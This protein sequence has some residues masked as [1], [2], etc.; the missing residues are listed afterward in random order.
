[1]Y[2]LIFLVQ[3]NFQAAVTNSAPD[4]MENA[5]IA[6]KQD[7]DFI[8]AAL[9]AKK[10]TFNSEESSFR[11]AADALVHMSDALKD[12]REV[13]MAAIQVSEGSC[14][15]N[16]S[17]NLKNDKDIVMATLK[18]GNKHCISRYWGEKIKNNKEV[19][20]YA[21]SPACNDPKAR[22]GSFAGSSLQWAV[23]DELQKDKDVVMAALS[24]W[25]CGGD[26]SLGDFF[27]AHFLG[28]KEVVLCGISVIAA[29]KKWVGARAYVELLNGLKSLK[30]VT[31]ELRNDRDVVMAALKVNGLELEHVSDE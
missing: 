28:D 7:K 1:M 9:A 15:R 6:T 10:G 8:M 5:S 31:P 24:N 26:Q 19:I 29:T 11:E 25:G 30:F 3:N 20:M 23:S 13:A 18:F 27:P 16:L 21:L 17:D 4:A 14:F 22:N 2:R 12:D